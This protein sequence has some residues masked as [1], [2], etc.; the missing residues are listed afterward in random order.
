MGIAPNPYS[1]IGGL[2]TEIW[3]KVADTAA[4]GS[5]DAGQTEELRKIVSDWM[6]EC[7]SDVYRGEP[8]IGLDGM[9]SGVVLV[10]SDEFA[11]SIMRAA[12]RIANSAKRDMQD[13]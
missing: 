11:T 4:A 10:I 12:V 2:E 8:A 5:L 6:R 7:P 1:L 9:M 3:R 13:A